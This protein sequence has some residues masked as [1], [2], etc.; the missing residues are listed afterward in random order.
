MIAHAPPPAPPPPI[1]FSRLFI[2]AYLVLA[3]S[4]VKLEDMDFSEL[5]TRAEEAHREADFYP[6]LCALIQIENHKAIY[7]RALMPGTDSMSKQ[8]AQGPCTCTLAACLC[9][10]H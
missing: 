1:P 9:N 2:E 4:D 5:C 3:P 10:S 6:H 8:R 7:K